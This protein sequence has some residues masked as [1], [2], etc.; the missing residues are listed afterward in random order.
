MQRR[1]Q[2]WVGLRL[3]W[4]SLNQVHGLPYTFI[5]DHGSVDCAMHSLSLCRILKQSKLKLGRNLT[6]RK[7]VKRKTMNRRLKQTSIEALFELFSRGAIVCSY[8]TS[9]SQRNLQCTHPDDICLCGCV[10]VWVCVCL[11]TFG[12]FKKKVNSSIFGSSRFFHYC[13]L[14]ARKTQ[15]IFFNL[16]FF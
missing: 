16:E 11:W 2:R 5:Y 3:W 6:G 14:A 8:E 4:T 9:W 10:G 1:H 15:D 7:R 12:S 13:K